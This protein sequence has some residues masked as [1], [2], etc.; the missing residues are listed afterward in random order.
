[1][2]REEIIMKLLNNHESFVQYIDSLSDED[3]LY[4]DPGKWTPGQQADHIYR[5]LKPLNRV[6]GLP[7]PIMKMV[8]GTS[9]RPSKDFDSL[10]EK[11]K[12]KL[13]AGGK[14]SGRYVPGPVWAEQR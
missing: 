9:N 6:M 5:S 4:A 13:S 8:F 3:F 1:M 2:F 12:G 11:Y 7:K 10:I 14:A